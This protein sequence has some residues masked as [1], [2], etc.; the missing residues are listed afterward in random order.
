MATLSRRL[1]ADF[2]DAV[3]GSRAARG[4]GTPAPAPCLG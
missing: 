3:K 1:P 4:R 2:P